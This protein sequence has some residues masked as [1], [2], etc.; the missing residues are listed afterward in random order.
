MN[1][2]PY[3][4]TA[5]EIK[6]E[7]RNLPDDASNKVIEETACR[8]EGLNYAPPIITPMERFLRIGMNGMLKETERILN[9]SAEEA[10]AIVLSEPAKC[11]NVKLQTISILLY[12]YKKLLLLRAG[13]NREW[14]NVGELYIYD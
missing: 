10:C 4:N 9:M 12:H 8:L 7:I 11:Q 2:I 14:D 1:N 3:H 5:E 13:S 6:D